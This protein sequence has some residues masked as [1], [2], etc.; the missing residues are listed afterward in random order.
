MYHLGIDG[1]GTKTKSCIKDKDGHT[2]YMGVAG[3]SSIDTVTLDETLNAI[4]ETY[5]DFIKTNKDIRFSSVCIGLGGIISK[6]D[7]FKVKTMA[8]KLPGVSTKT[9]IDIKND[10]EIALGSGLLFDEGMVLICGTGSVAFGKD[11]SGHQHKAGGWGY[12]EGDSGSSYDLGLKSLKHVIRALD[13]RDVKTLFTKAVMKHIHMKNPS[14]FIHIL[15]EKYLDRTWIAG[16]APLV[17]KYA[18]RHDLNAINIVDEATNDLCDLISAVYK[19][20][21]EKSY[22]LVVVGSLGH[23]KGFKHVLN[24]KFNTR[25]PNIKVIQPVIEPCEAAAMIAIKNIQI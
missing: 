18:L 15:D 20:L 3:P 25:F 4:I 5:N 2:L 7:K 14:D 8:K 1:G 12:K 9:K 6:D 23:A 24:Q 10:M 22:A 21:D 16:L 17:T 11:K 13:G 19:K